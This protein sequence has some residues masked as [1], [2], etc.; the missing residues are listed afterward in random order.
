[1]MKKVL[2]ASDHA[3]VNLKQTLITAVT[4]W[5]YTSQ[6]LGPCDLQPVDYPDYARNLCEA[7]LAS[8]GD[9]GVLICGS[10]IGMSIMA[11]RFKG[12]RGALCLSTEMANLSRR[13]N[14]ANVLILGARLTTCS[15]AATDI[16]KTFLDTPYEGGR[17]DQRISKFDI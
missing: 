13:H 2:F 3:G 6:D 5:G 16:L 10:G 11:N 1:M 9:I 12:I 7:L 14:N 15:E 17:H 8:Q 4:S